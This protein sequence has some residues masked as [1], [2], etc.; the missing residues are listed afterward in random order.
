MEPPEFLSDDLRPIWVEVVASLPPARKINPI[1]LEAYCA[2]IKALRSASGHVREH[3]V[4]IEDAQGRRVAN[5]ALQVIRDMHSAL[6]K[7]G[8]EFSPVSTIRRRPGTMYSATR[9]SVA[10]AKHLSGRKE[11]SGAIEAVCT[12]A[13]LIDEAQREGIEALQKA[14]FGTIPS[15]LKGCSELQITP[16][17]VPAAEPTGP[18]T[19][20]RSKLQVLQGGAG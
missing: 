17:A 19:S 9:A 2:Q 6:S 1:H 11:Y 13:W 20:K 10:A 18:S 3:G 12:L 5:P 7:W 14:A 15:Y 16:A 8:N 4:T